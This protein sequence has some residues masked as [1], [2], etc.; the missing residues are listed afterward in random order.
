MRQP[1]NLN[2]E[3]LNP[4]SLDVRFLKAEVFFLV[5]HLKVEADKK[6]GNA[7]AGQHTDLAALLG[8]HEVT[9]HVRGSHQRLLLLQ[10]VY[11][12][13][14]QGTVRESDIS[15]TGGGHFEIFRCNGQ[16]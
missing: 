9:L 12:S 3:F 6:G 13:I 16:I 1:Y 14:R 10:A 4:K 8:R 5:N 7:E 15:K 11:P 2:F